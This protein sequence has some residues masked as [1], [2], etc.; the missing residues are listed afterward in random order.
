M[1]LSTRLGYSI[2]DYFDLNAEFNLGIGSYDE[3]DDFSIDEIDTFSVFVQTN[4]PQ[5]KEY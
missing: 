5:E 1:S 3:E 2:N 4:I